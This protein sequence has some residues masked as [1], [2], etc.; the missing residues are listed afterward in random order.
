MMPDTKTNAEILAVVKTYVDGMCQNDPA[1]LRDAMHEKSCCIGHYDGG[2]EWD[3]RDAFIAAVG[4]AVDTPDP[5][6]WH[7]VNAISIVGDVAVVQV[8]DIWLG[9]HFDDTLT[10]LRHENRW[11]IVS[12]VF[13]LRRDG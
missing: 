10:L 6:P 7:V 11:V 13:F 5:A 1:K 8:E 12:K 3:T 9:M 4:K 2:L